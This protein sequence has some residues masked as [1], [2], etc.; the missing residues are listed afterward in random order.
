MFDIANRQTIKMISSVARKLYRSPKG[1]VLRDCAPHFTEDDF[2][3]T[4]FLHIIEKRHLFDDTKACFSTW[5]NTVAFNLLSTLTKKETGNFSG[6]DPETGRTL[7]SKTSTGKTYTIHTF[8]KHLSFDAPLNDDE[9]ESLKNYLSTRLIDPVF[10]EKYDNYSEYITEGSITEIQQ[11]DFSY[12]V[13]Q[14]INYLDS[15]DDIES[16]RFILRY[17]NRKIPFTLRSMFAMFINERLTLEQLHNCVCNIETEDAVSR[18]TFNRL[19][20]SIEEAVYTVSQQ[21]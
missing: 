2:V 8:I 5:V 7:K 14:I 13:R 11:N 1:S 3:Q 9:Q 12:R 20:H 4:L 15:G 10:A 17:R 16:T 21:E 18:T 19:I 6:K